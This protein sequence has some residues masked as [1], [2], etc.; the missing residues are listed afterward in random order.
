MVRSRLS[1]ASEDDCAQAFV[2]QFFD[3]QA[4]LGPDI[5]AQ[6]N[7]TKQRTFREPYFRKPSFRAA[8]L[9]DGRSASV[10]SQPITPAK[11]TF[12]AI[13][14]GTQTLAGDGFKLFE[15]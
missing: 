8:D 12:A 10:A 13:A 5:V 6:D 11:K 15:F 2:A 3:H 1:I 7:A 9:G 14:P 4:G